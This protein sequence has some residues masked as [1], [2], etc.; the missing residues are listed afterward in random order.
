[1]TFSSLSV[2]AIII[3]VIHIHRFIGVVRSGGPRDPFHLVSINP[4]APRVQLSDFFNPERRGPANS[5][6]IYDQDGILGINW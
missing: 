6:E 2:A 3:G 1:M 5:C 4:F